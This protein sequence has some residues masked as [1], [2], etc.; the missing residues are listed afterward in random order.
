MVKSKEDLLFV[1]AVVL[2]GLTALIMVVRHEYCSHR[3]AMHEVR[4]A[5]SSTEAA[6][7]DCISRAP[8]C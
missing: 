5:A 4:C 6:Y 8:E 7:Q 3:R 1:V 2:W